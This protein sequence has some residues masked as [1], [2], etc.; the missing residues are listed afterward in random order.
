MRVYLA[1][2]PFDMRKS[3][4][5]LMG[6]VQ[7]RWREDPFSGNLFVFVSRRCDRLKVL[8][9]DHGGFVLFY[10]RL[11]A[12]KFRL[13]KVAASADR[14]RLEPTDLAMLLRG[15]D[16]SRVRRPVPWMPTAGMMGCPPSPPA[17]R[18]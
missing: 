9:F 1:T 14:I 4:D 7:G 15:I 3:I 18:T 13:P 11:E 16:F 17:F 6:V 5:G 10:K 12:G 8:Y 2:E